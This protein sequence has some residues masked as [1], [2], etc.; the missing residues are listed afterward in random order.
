MHN[1]TQQF[2]QPSGYS[3]SPSPRQYD[4]VMLCNL[5]CSSTILTSYQSIEQ[6]QS[7]FGKNSE[8][9]SLKKSSSPPSRSVSIPP[10]PHLHRSISIP[11]APRLYRRSQ[12][13]SLESMSRA[14]TPQAES[15]SRSPSIESR[16]TVDQ[17]GFIYNTLIP[18]VQSSVSSQRTLVPD[19][20]SSPPPNEQ[21]AHTRSMTSDVEITR[22]VFNPRS[23]HLA[24]TQRSR[25]RIR[26]GNQRTR[27]LTRR[28]P[29]TPAQIRWRL[30]GIRRPRPEQRRPI[31][32]PS[33]R[34]II[35]IIDSDN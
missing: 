17:D 18:T 4:E 32:G 6:M 26:S 34:T 8:K 31:D 14:P 1:N 15:R 24:E 33:T 23:R 21:P 11:S 3:E 19:P 2:P 7:D 28:Q 20:S 13:P 30:E 5:I 27:A 16:P 35:E 22:T 9:E 25:R 29:L 12:A 10:A